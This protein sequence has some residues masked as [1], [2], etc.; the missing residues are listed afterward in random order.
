MYKRQAL[1][2]DA[3]GYLDAL[4]G[5]GLCLGLRQAKSL[6][7]A[8]LAK[9]PKSYPS[10]HRA[11]KARHHFVVNSLLW[12][13]H[14]PQLRQRV[15]QALAISPRLFQSVIQFAVE[16]ANWT[17]L[18]SPDL[19]RFLFYLITGSSKPSI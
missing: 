18:L 8:I 7:Q 12:L 19:P 9:N 16:E 14:Q 6:A 3:A 5:E 4:T 17:T 13:L 1:V 11:I 15:F 2:G 10:Q